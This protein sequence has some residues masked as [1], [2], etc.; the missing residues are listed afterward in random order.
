[1]DAAAITAILDDLNEMAAAILKKDVK[2]LQTMKGEFDEYVAKIYSKMSPLSQ[3]VAKREFEKCRVCAR[4]WIKVYCDNTYNADAKAD[5]LREEAMEFF[6]TVDERIITVQKNFFF[7]GMIDE[8]LNPSKPFSKRK[9]EAK[10]AN[11]R[12]RMLAR[13]QNLKATCKTASDT[14]AAAILED[15]LWFFG[16]DRQFLHSSEEGLNDE[17]ALDYLLKRHE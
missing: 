9:R 3:D 16:D 1:M 10:M 17:E 12:I 15:R 14:G 2:D 13:E 7:L 6:F 11:A 5:L 4:E 8:I